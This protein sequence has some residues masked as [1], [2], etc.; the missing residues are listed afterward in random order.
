MKRSRSRAILLCFLCILQLLDAARVVAEDVSVATEVWPPFRIGDPEHPNAL[1]GIDIDLLEMLSKRL[2][3]SCRVRRMPWA[4]CLESM[5]SGDADLIT[6]LARTPERAEFIR[7]SAIPYHTVFPAFYVKK[8][9]ADRIRSY[10]DL[11]RVTIGYSLKSAYFEPFDSDERLSKI[12]V[13]TERQL[14]QMLALGRLEAIVGTGANVDYDISIMGLWGDIEKAAYRP[15]AHTGLHVGISRKS[16]LMERAEEID[17]ILE[18]LV[19][20]GRLL[21]VLETYFYGSPP[22][23]G[24]AGDGE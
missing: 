10:E 7:Y 14:I 17:R 12:G 4:R 16:P 6:G 18:Y 2:G 9:T 21:P 22:R 13:S 20:S 1:T 8:G 5:R 24:A 15:D 3:I 11:R 19:Q 23:D